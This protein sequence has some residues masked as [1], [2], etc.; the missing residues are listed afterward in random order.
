MIFLSASSCHMVI[1]VGRYET[2][3]S[4]VTVDLTVYD[5]Q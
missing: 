1:R 4:H 3:Y 2:C 5:V